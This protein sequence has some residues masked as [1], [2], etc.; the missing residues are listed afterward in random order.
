MSSK[1]QQECSA[2]ARESRMRFDTPVS[3]V[4]G[5]EGDG[6]WL[7][8]RNPILMQLFVSVGFPFC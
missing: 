5:P 3:G 8:D 1:G 2:I 4:K 6:V 7:R